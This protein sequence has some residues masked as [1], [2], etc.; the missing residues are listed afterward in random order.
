MVNSRQVTRS[1]HSA[2]RAGA[3]QLRVCSPMQAGPADRVPLLGLGGAV[4]LLALGP[5]RTADAIWGGS[6]GIFGKKPEPVQSPDFHGAAGASDLERLVDAFLRYCAT[7]DTYWILNCAEAISNATPADRNAH[8]S[9]NSQERPWK[10]I[11]AVADQGEQDKDHGLIAKLGLMCQVWNRMILKQ[12]PIHQMSRLARAPL[13]IELGLYKSALTALFVMP[14]ADALV[15][16]GEQ[17]W[18]VREALEQISHCVMMLIN[19]GVP[20]DTELHRLASR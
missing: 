2:G 19:E 18:S 4:R 10:W 13:D 8:A 16:G 9:S 6:V 17:V 1:T 7:G 3:V 5:Q 14:P 11:K 20:V 15:S 12:E